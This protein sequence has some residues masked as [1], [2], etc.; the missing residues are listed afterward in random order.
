M[1]L[2]V[3]ENE[4]SSDKGPSRVKVMHVRNVRRRTL[5]PEV[6]AAVEAGSTLYIGSSQTASPTRSNP[7]SVSLMPILTK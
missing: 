5:A 1:A 3:W 2:T 6:R 7:I 4:R